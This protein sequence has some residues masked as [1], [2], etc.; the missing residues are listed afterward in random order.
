MAR[1][2][3]GLAVAVVVG[4][5][6]CTSNDAKPPTPQSICRARFANVLD[7]QAD[8]VQGVTEVGP[9]PISAPPGHLGTYTDSTPI[10]LCLVGKPT[11]DLDSAIAITPDGKSFT[12][13]KQGGSIHL[14]KPT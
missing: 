3:A 2:C 10:T 12:V 11:D 7:A 9:R 8:T 14:M 4:L 13:W 6:A 5:T 1:V